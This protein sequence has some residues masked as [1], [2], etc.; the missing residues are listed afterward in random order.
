[1]VLQIMKSE[2]ELKVNDTDTQSDTTSEMSDEGYRSLPVN[3]KEDAE[4]NGNYNLFTTLSGAKFALFACRTS[5]S[6][7]GRR[8]ERRRPEEDS[9]LP[10][11]RQRRRQVAKTCAKTHT[12]TTG[13]V[14][15]EG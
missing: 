4:D 9:V 14:L 2:V 6:L 3:K 13:E 15:R 5:T 8:P 11:L 7:H 1:M 10:N 12:K